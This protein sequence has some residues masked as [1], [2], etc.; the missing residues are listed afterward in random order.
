MTDPLSLGTL[1]N[2]TSAACVY[3][4]LVAAQS[5][6]TVPSVGSSSATVTNV[7]TLTYSASSGGPTQQATASAPVTIV[8]PILTFAKS[9]T[10]VTPPILDDPS[11]TVASDANA[12]AFLPMRQVATGTATTPPT[13][14]SRLPRRSTATRRQRHTDRHNA[15]ALAHRRSA[16][17][18]NADCNRGHSSRRH[19]R[20]DHGDTLAERY[21]SDCARQPSLPQRR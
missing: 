19:A 6:G 3:P 11:F 9:S 4:V 20:Y 2:P 17:N 13:A 10:V 1:S 16:I 14:T 15:N 18:V 8:A 7:A 21:A 5:D 12:F